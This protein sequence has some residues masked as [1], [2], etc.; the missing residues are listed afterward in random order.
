MKHDINKGDRPDV[1]QERAKLIDYAANQLRKLREY[2]EHPF[3]FENFAE[4]YLKAKA[5]IVVHVRTKTWRQPVEFL[6]VFDNA[7]RTDSTTTVGIK[8]KPLKGRASTKLRDYQGRE[9]GRRYEKSVLIDNVESMKCP[10]KFIPCFIWL[11]NLDQLEH[12]L[13]GAMYFSLKSGFKTLPVIEDGKR[14]VVVRCASVGL[15]DLSGQMIQSRAKIVDR[16]TQNK[17]NFDGDIRR[18]TRLYDS[19]AGLRL[20]LTNGA[21]CAGFEK[22]SPFNPEIVDVLVGLLND[23]RSTEH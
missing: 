20:V 1:L 9:C 10:Q 4:S 21:I 5:R 14:S 12:I 15:D 11:E 17:R 2:G 7:W 8:R 19:I 3:S 13:A 23:R 18:D 22:E 16:V 6:A